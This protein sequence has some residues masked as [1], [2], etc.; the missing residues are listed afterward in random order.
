MNEHFPSPTP[1]DSS[2]TPEQFTDDE[3]TPETL[4][5]IEEGFKTLSEINGEATYERKHDIIFTDAATPR[6]A[7]IITIVANSRDRAN[8]VTNSDL[9]IILPPLADEFKDTS[10]FT[11]PPLIIFNKTQSGLEATFLANDMYTPHEIVEPLTKQAGLPESLRQA[12]HVTKEALGADGDYDSLNLAGGERNFILNDEQ[13]DALWVSTQ[14]E[15]DK[16]PSETPTKASWNGGGSFKVTLQNGTYIDHASTEARIVDNTFTLIFADIVTDQFN[17]YQQLDEDTGSVSYT[18]K[19]QASPGELPPLTAEDL[20]HH[21][22]VVIPVSELTDDQSSN[23]DIPGYAPPHVDYPKAGYVVRRRDEG[24]G[25]QDIDYFPHE[26]T[27]VEYA[28]YLY[29]MLLFAKKDAGKLNQTQAEKVLRTINGLIEH[30]KA[31]P[32]S[33]EAAEES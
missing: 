21:P 10:G 19:V 15:M 17:F 3:P 11:I 2:H 9:R 27:A 6:Q 26:K 4:R 1:D 18:F 5:A 30:I 14:E 12:L 31:H 23:P 22:Y 8:D 28:D 16:H 33:D 20:R 7:E 24:E 25:V 32:G 13:Y 29:Q